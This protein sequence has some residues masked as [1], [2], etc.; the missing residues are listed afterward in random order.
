MLPP[1]LT[2]FLGEDEAKK[3]EDTP[4]SIALLLEFPRP[5]TSKDSQCHPIH[6]GGAWPKVPAKP[7]AGQSQYHTQPRSTG[8]LNPVNQPHRWIQSEMG[9]TRH[10]NWWRKIKA[11][12]RMTMGSH[13]I[14]EGLTDPEALHYAQCQ[15]EAFRLPAAQQEASGWW[16]ARPGLSGLCLEDF[17]PQG[18]LGCE[19]GTDHGPSLGPKGLCQR[20][21]GQSRH[22]L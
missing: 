21:G 16:G 17:L 18:F 3:W 15:V 20:V 2:L 19:V 14:K 13:I 7:S 5:S 1:G 10:P 11:S 22:S 4:S 8:G 12:G 6:L 9:K